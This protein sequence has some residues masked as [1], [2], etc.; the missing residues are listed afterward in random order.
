MNKRCSTKPYF[1]NRK[2]NQ[3]IQWAIPFFGVVLSF[4]HNKAH[5]YLRGAH[6]HKQ[7][8][9]RVRKETHFDYIRQHFNKNWEKFLLYTKFQ[10]NHSTTQTSLTALYGEF[11]PYTSLPTSIHLCP[12]TWQ[13]QFVAFARALV[14]GQ[15]S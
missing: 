11:L 15:M 7:F 12:T 14:P 2:G 3:K 10:W 1:M 9:I 13:A 8:S 5:L 4:A 6:I